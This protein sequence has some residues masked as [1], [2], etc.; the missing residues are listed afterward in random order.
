MGALLE[1]AAARRDAKAYNRQRGL[2]SPKLINYG[3]QRRSGGSIVAAIEFDNCLTFAA[4]TPK[5]P[6]ATRLPALLAGQT[7]WPW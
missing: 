6:K 4:K 3:A 2:F 5:T 7:E 1:L